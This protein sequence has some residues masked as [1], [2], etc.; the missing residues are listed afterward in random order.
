MNEEIQQKMKRENSKYICYFEYSR[1][2]FPRLQDKRVG[3][4]KKS[5]IILY[6]IFYLPWIRQKMKRIH[7]KKT[8]KTHFK[9]NPFF[10]YILE[11]KLFLVVK[12]QHFMNSTETFLQELNILE[13]YF[14]FLQ[15]KLHT[16]C[17]SFEF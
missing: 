15:F 13:S 1:F 16:F 8:L 6:P 10:G 14:L 12:S 17:P 3:I 5:S 7:L 9:N 4:S 11:A 2:G